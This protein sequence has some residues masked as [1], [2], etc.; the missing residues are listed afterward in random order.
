MKGA[1][2]VRPDWVIGSAYAAITFSY[3]VAWY[4]GAIHGFV[5]KDQ[6]DPEGKRMKWSRFAILAG[7]TFLQ[8][9]ELV[10]TSGTLE[11]VHTVVHKENPEP[12][13]SFVKSGG[14][15]LPAADYC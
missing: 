15:S 14:I 2:I 4:M 3:E 6:T 12:V 1:G 11:Q 13:I 7:S 5:E 9:E 8:V 10:T